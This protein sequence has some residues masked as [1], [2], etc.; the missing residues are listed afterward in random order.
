MRLLVGSSEQ[1]YVARWQ[2]LQ[3]FAARFSAGSLHD[4]FM[5]LSADDLKIF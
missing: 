3:L 1:L 2:H 5:G 4:D